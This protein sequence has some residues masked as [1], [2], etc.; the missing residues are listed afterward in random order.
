MAKAVLNIMNSTSGFAGFRFKFL[1]D[2]RTPM[3]NMSKE[4]RKK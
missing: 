2:S 1:P 3:S 4:G